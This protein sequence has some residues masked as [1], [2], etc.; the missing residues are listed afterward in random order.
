MLSI[1]WQEIRAAPLRFA[2]S[3]ASI[4]IAIVATLVTAALYLGLLEGIVSYLQTLDGDLVVTEPGGSAVVLR[5]SSSLPPE[6]VAQV[7]RVPGALTV[8]ALYG[9]RVWL[10]VADREA[11]VFAVGL[12]RTDR[13]GGPV[14]VLAGESRPRI[15]EIVVDRVLARDLDLDLGDEVEFGRARLRV[16][17]IASGGNAMVGTYAFVHRGALMLAGAGPPSYLFVR[18]APGVEPVALAREISSLGLRVF[19][20]ERFVARN[21]AMAEELLLPVLLLLIAVAAAGGGA[22]VGLTLYTAAL[23]RRAD[24]G[25]LK[26]IGF[27]DRR[28]CGTAV[29]AAGIATSAGLALGVTGAFLVVALLGAYEPRFEATVAPWLLAAVSVG[30]VAVG[31]VATLLPVRAIA[32]VDPG[33]V[34]RI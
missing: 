17:G 23:D 14:R 1:A 12:Y 5:S 27:S 28:L 20:R 19:T 34:L 31:M 7:E 32:R 6:T 22:V 3:I 10:Q 33:L 24:Y 25:L 29:L 30:T 15:D 16:A 2:A 8:H 11:L 13:A 4:A 9:R 21:R 18:A 26:A